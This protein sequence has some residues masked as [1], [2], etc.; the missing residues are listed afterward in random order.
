MPFLLSV[1]GEDL[2]DRQHTGKKRRHTAG[3]LL[4]V[5]ESF[6]IALLHPRHLQLD[7]GGTWVMR[8]LQGISLTRSMR[9]CLCSL[10][11]GWSCSIS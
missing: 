5:F 7:E 8:R 1:F 11:T 4:A 2:S 9:V 6:T 3:A 10:L